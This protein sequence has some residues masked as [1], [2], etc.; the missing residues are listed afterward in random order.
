MVRAVIEGWLLG[1]STGPYCFGA[2]AP[3]LVPY[4]CAAGASTWSGNVRIIGEFLVGR[5]LAYLLFGAAV[6]WVGELVKPHLSQQVAAIAL[7]V[8]S[9]V[10]I[11]CAVVKG[12]PH[13]RLCAWSAR[14]LPMSRMPLVLGL[15]IGINVCPPFL[16]AMAR[17]LQIGGLATGVVFF[18]GFFAGT[19]LSTLPLLS[20][21]PLTRNVRVQRV[22]TYAAIIVGGWFLLSAWV[23][24]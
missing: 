21:S 5:F 15:L 10:M 14:R 13:W 1:L 2:C 22:G 18:L 7:V 9:T 19:T 12:L 11:L 6:G 8:T 17:L 23:G 20:L 4:L 3:F 24:R 16:V